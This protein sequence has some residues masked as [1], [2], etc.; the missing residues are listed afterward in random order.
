MMQ[1]CFNIIYILYNIAYRISYIVY[2]VVNNSQ[3]KRRLHI[4][5]IKIKAV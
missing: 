5:W 2:N 4:L 1:V 3:R